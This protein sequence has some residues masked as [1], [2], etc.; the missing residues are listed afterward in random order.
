[1][2]P[3]WWEITLVHSITL[4][5]EKD[6]CMLAYIFQDCNQYTIWTWGT[7]NQHNPDALLDLSVDG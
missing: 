3:C 2:F 4:F 6:H 1:M 5:H 7:V